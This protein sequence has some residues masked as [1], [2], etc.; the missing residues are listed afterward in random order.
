MP[1]V[2]FLGFVSAFAFGQEPKKSIPP[3]PA[4]RRADA[5]AIYSAVLARPSLSHP[6][7][8]E[9][10]LIEEFSGL[11]MEESTDPQRC[12]GVPEPYRT[13]FAELLADRAA[14]SEARFQ[15]E[16]AFTS[17]KPYDLISEEQAEEFRKL[18]STPGRSTNEVDLFRGATDLITLGNVY[19]DR[20]R[21]L[22][23]VHMWAYCGSLC[24]YGTWRV[25]V[26]R[27]GGYQEQ[28]WVTCM[29]IAYSSPRSVVPPH[30]RP[31]STGDFRANQR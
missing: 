28:N 8:N 10:Y 21:T 4:D 31:R 3:I 27:G 15:F 1:L 19:F 22:A 26:N 20:K 24:G 5:Y 6:N 30:H 14:H 18:R 12:I 7:E 9:K 29:T 13:R 16:R 23:A 2:V 25:F 17:P 11:A